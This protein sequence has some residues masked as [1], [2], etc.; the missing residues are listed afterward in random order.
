[1]VL[2]LPPVWPACPLIL[3][4]AWRPVDSMRWRLSGSSN[5]L[6]S[7]SLWWGLPGSELRV[8]WAWT[9]PTCKGGESSM[10]LM[11]FLRWHHLLLRLI[12][13]SLGRYPH[14]LW[15]ILESLGRYPHPLWLIL[16]SLGRYPHPP[17]LILE[18]LR[19]YHHLL[20]LIL[21]LSCWLGAEVKIASTIHLAIV[22]IAAGWCRWTVVIKSCLASP[23]SA[24]V[25]IL[26]T[27]QGTRVCPLGHEKIKSGWG[28]TFLEGRT[29]EVGS[30]SGT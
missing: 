30:W 5:M 18:S 24:L 20:R 15:L 28:K 3:P 4:F 27:W 25:R 13:E 11:L 9:V 8:W 14:P 19:R 1:M 26:R 7:W 21:V 10:L 17:W 12:L 2:V 16:E 6:L 22:V 23:Q 29:P